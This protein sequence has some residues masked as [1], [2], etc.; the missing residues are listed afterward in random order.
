M[1][2]DYRLFREAFGNPEFAVYPGHPVT[3]AWVIVQAFPTFDSAFKNT[4]FDFP[5]ALGSPDIPGAGGCVYGALDFLSSLRKGT[6][7]E[8]EAF[9]R[10]DEYWTT[11]DDNRTQ[12]PEKWQEGQKQADRIK[13]L[14]RAHRGWWK[15]PRPALQRVAEGAV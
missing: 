7:S 8:V 4:E 6:C 13:E 1:A 5:A 3:I 14:L 11:T 2:A 10:A 9:R 15:K 12:Y